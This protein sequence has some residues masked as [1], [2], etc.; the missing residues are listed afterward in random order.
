MCIQAKKKFGILNYDVNNAIKEVN[1]CPSVF[2]GPLLASLYLEIK[3]FLPF[4][5]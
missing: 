3:Y 5:S 1:I 4:L 2:R